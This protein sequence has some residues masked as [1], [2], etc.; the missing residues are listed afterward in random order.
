WAQAKYGDTPKYDVIEVTGPDHDRRF[1]VQVSV[2]GE[3][4]GRGTGRSKQ[5]AAHEA[6]GCAMEN[7]A[8]FENGTGS[9]PPSEEALENN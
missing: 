8:A 9:A 1:T 4:W 7:V 2:K 5:V 6:A 3:P